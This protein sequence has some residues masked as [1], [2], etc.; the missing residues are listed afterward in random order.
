MKLLTVSWPAVDTSAFCF[1]NK[2]P[3]DRLDSGFTPPLAWHHAWLWVHIGTCGR[4]VP[5]HTHKGSAEDEEAY[6]AEAAHC[7]MVGFGMCCPYSQEPALGRAM[8]VYFGGRGGMDT[9]SFTAVFLQMKNDL[10]CYGR[11]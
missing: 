10:P 1:R 9:H 8:E 11:V 2:V 3:G 4:A 7:P 6:R 5:V